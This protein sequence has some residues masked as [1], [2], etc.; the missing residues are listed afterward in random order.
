MY[1]S[2][3]AFWAT[4]NVQDISCVPEEEKISLCNAQSQTRSISND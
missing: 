4:D 2:E 1:L 3:K